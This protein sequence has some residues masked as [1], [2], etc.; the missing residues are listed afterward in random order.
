[1]R[2]FTRLLLPVLLTFGVAWAV[3][4]GGGVG[5]SAQVSPIPAAS[6]GGWTDAGTWL[7]LA[8]LTD[9]VVIGSATRNGGKLEVLATTEQLRLSYD[10][11]NYTA[12][13]VGSTGNPTINPSGSGATAKV[14]ITDNLVVSGMGPHAFG[15]T[16]YDFVALRVGGS[17]TS[18]GASTTT[19]GTR[20]ERAIT[21]AAGDITGHWGS[22]FYDNITTQGNAE[23]IA[24]VAQAYFYEPRI[25][26]GAGDMITNADTVYIANAPTE[27]TT[28]S[29]LRVGGGA[30][31][32][33]GEL[34]LATYAAAPAGADC[35]AAA[36]SNKVVW[37]STNDVLWVCSGA[38]GWRQI[39]TAAP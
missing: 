21:A 17:F 37:D 16:V 3:S 10:N 18:G 11:A 6:G 15:T 22:F 8:T 31:R 13:T 25:T 23:T 2:T 30:T 32:L 36:E 28:N 27:G 9:N 29:A 12:F 20:W 38:S 7:R 5:V 14:T 24:F 1:M 35:D 34:F 19:E 39:A 26:V 4:T 33:L